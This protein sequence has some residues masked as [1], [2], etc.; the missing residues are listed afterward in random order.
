M[1]D[2]GTEATVEVSAENVGENA[3]V[4]AGANLGDNTEVEASVTVPDPTTETNDDPDRL[5]ILE[6]I[7]TALSETV[8]GVVKQLTDQTPDVQPQKLP[9]TAWGGKK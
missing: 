9:W 3:T 6:N 4:E 5:A 8:E 2:N 1:P 7:V